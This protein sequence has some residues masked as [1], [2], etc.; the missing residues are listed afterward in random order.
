MLKVKKAYVQSNISDKF[1]VQ[2]NILHNPNSLY[3]R[4]YSLARQIF[5]NTQL[6][7]KAVF[8]KPPSRYTEINVSDSRRSA[9][10]GAGTR[11]RHKQMDKRDEDQL[12]SFMVEKFK[13]NSP[14][15]P[16]YLKWMRMYIAFSKNDRSMPDSQAEFLVFLGMRKEPWQVKQA[17]RAVTI[18]QAFMRKSSDEGNS[19]QR[20][21]RM[22]LQNIACE[23][24]IRKMQSE[25]RFQNKSMQTERSYLYWVKDFY[26]HAASAGSARLNA[27]NQDTLKAYLTYL[28]I[29]RSVAV[30]T[31]KQAFNAILFLF[32]RVLDIPVENLHDV[33][34]SS[35]PRSLPV[36]L[37]RKEVDKILRRLNHPYDLMAQIIYGGGLRLSECL[38][39]RIKDIDFQNTILTVRSGKGDKDRRTLLP[40]KSIADLK[41]HLRSIRKYFEDD[42]FHNR[43]GV[44]LPKALERKY[45]NAG[46][47]WGWFWVF[48][49]A[50]ISV[51]PRSGIAR[52][53]HLFSS[54]LQKTFKLALRSTDVTKNASVH[55]LRHSF[56]THLVENGYDIRT[57]QELLGHSNV[58]NTMI[59]THV[60]ARNKLGVISPLDMHES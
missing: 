16:H 55:T 37:S 40:G 47:E 18:Y 36:V 49:S 46:K 9:A 45:P 7:V 32:R 20:H 8:C 31:Q 21:A 38:K 51:D 4:I 41:A 15:I 27:F 48:P 39:L 5:D 60:A 17:E 28:A 12:V 25:L 22:P 53:H 13:V 33:V 24:V 19:Q 59:Y 26:R 42:R 29:E 2:H 43:P 52:R 23:R 10:A 6:H 14:K 11:R 57:V 3:F 34:R 58:S 44:E 54:S 50:K 56:A 35:K 1:F 30:S